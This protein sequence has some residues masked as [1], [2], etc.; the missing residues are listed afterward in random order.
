[1]KIKILTVIFILS[2]FSETLAQIKSNYARGFEIGFAEGYCYNRQ[3]VDCF[4]PITPL[5][6]LPRVNENRENYTEGY[7]RGFQFG[8]DLERRNNALDNTDVN[9][10]NELVQFNNYVSQQP[11]SAMVAIGMLKQRK[12]D[13]R[14]EW[15]QN[16]MTNLIGVLRTLYQDFPEQDKIIKNET[17]NLVKQLKPYAASDFADDYVFKRI[18]S[19]FNSVERSCY[20]NYNYLV[21]QQ[22]EIYS[23]ENEVEYSEQKVSK[24]L[25]P[26][27]NENIPRTQSV[28]SYAPI[29]KTPNLTNSDKI[30]Y[31][32]NNTVEILEKYNDN[33]YKVSCDGVVGYM[34]KMWF[35]N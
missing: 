16:K 19:I 11:V 18:K 3:T 6:P 20:N 4:R 33:I 35:T 1:M 29:F 31:A 8:L 34:I 30:G 24:P 13:A 17:G 15:I 14:V 12:Y 23:S 21:S 27:V 5:S 32:K 9:L 25:K 28:V 22:N 7:N 2:I 10:R 26:T